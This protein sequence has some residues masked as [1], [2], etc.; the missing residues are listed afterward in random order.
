MLDAYTK[1]LETSANSTNNATA[2]DRAADVR[3]SLGRLTALLNDIERD[4]H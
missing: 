3:R 1:R 4:V 2:R